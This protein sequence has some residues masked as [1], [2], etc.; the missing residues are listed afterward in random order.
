MTVSR[1]TA[2]V[3]GT[4]L[5]LALA[6][7]SPLAQAED[8]VATMVFDKPGDHSWTVP[9]G[10]VPQFGTVELWGGGGGGGGAGGGAGAG[11]GGGGGRHYSMG[12]FGGTGGNGGGGGGGAGGGYVKCELYL[13]AGNRLTIR[14]GGAGRNGAQGSTPGKGGEGGTGGEGTFTSARSGTNGTGPGTPYARSGGRG[15]NTQIWYVNAQGNPDVLARAHGADGGKAAL[16]LATAGKGGPRG[17][18]DDVNTPK[19]AD[20]TSAAGGNG[21]TGGNIERGVVSCEHSST[22]ASS[23]GSA[24]GSAQGTRGGGGGDAGKDLDATVTPVYGQGGAGGNG[25]AGGKGG[26]R[27]IARPGDEDSK[28]GKDG[29]DG[30]AGGNGLPGHDGAVRFTWTPDNS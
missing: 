7:V 4:A 22:L 23:L 14:V 5:T 13:A 2:V 1:R 10:V 27:G 25:G 12:G 20:G 28:D 15:G 8:A 19:G 21:G 11:G 29:G 6:C 26:D 3:A 30:A 24:G 16:G 9:A 18:S 17:E